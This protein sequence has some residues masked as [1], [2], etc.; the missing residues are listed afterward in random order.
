MFG[1]NKLWRFV[2]IWLFAAVGMAFTQAQTRHS[3]A[4]GERKS[5]SEVS[6]KTAADEEEEAASGSLAHASSQE[7][8]REGYQQN[9]QHQIV[10]LGDIAMGIAGMLSNLDGIGRPLSLSVRYHLP[11]PSTYHW[12]ALEMGVD[13]IF[14][15]GEDSWQEMLACVPIEFFW[16]FRY[17]PRFALYWKFGLGPFLLY[18]GSLNVVAFPA[19]TL[20]LG[21]IW[22]FSKIAHLR[23]EMGFPGILRLGIGFG[24]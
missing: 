18:H 10:L 21:L 12:I 24:F 22:D 2:A 11:L 16:G 23:V 4:F 13:L 1:H 7:N 19:I 15:F 14:L 6:A 3:E 5:A 9:R 8:P 20:Q 17:T